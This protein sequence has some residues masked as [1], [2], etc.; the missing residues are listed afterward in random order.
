MCEDAHSDHFPAPKF[1]TLSLILDP[2]SPKADEVPLRPLRGGG[3]GGSGG[4]GGGSGSGSGV[5]NGGGVGVGSVIIEVAKSGSSRSSAGD[6]DCGGLQAQV[7][8]NG[9]P[10]SHDSRSSPTSFNYVRAVVK[11][12]NYDKLN[13]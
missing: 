6:A 9:V 11:T 10:R 13:V 3:G 8:V 4:G 12:P 5:G 7:I 2:S 1:T